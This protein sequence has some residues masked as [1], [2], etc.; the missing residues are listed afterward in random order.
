M[1]N[2][3][4]ILNIE[5]QLKQSKTYIFL[6]FAIVYC[7]ISFPNLDNFHASAYDLGIYNNSIYQYGH[8]INNPHP[9]GHL[10]LTNFLG[11][12]FALYTI[13]FSP[14]HYIFGIY[15]LL[16]IQIVF[17]LL[18]GYG[19]Y[20]L[21]KHMYPETILP[22]ISLFH[23]FTFYGIISALGFGYHDNVVASMLIPWFIYFLYI[24][25]IKLVIMF[26]ILICIGK[27][28][29]PLILSFIIIGYMLIFK[30]DTKKIKLLTLILIFSILYMIIV[31]KF[32]MPFFMRENVVYGHTANY[33]VLGNTLHEML[34]NIIFK[35]KYLITVLFTNHNNVIDY[36]SLKQE[37][38]MCLLLSGGIALL[39]KPEFLIMLIPIVFQKM[40]NNDQGK[41]GT[42]LHYSIEF[43]PIIILALYTTLNYLHNIKY[44]ISVAIVFC[45]LSYSVS[46]S[47]LFH[48]N[49][50]LQYNYLANFLNKGH[51]QSYFNKKSYNKL[52]SMI[53]EDAKLSTNNYFG[54]NLAFRKWIFLLP[55][56]VDANYIFLGISNYDF[57]QTESDLKNLV[58][59]LKNSKEWE[60]IAS[61]NE[62]YLFKKIN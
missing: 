31:I 32:I 19:I 18:G 49:G 45:F 56:I 60:L 22:E 51:Y 4:F 12:H 43:A 40:Y 47:R 59:N 3:Y 11:D 13:I 30:N 35:S 1:I 15:T 9:Y 29:M 21:V 52:V 20:T 37:T 28:N 54:P 17:I 57:L 36:D 14:L 10:A 61:E 23:F 55:D 53:P 27:E 39:I 2:T 50:D 41:W 48:R 8:L 33:S 6:L 58:Q 42:D 46:F 25:R 5:N 34:H 24:N 26:A 7:L 62:M 38:Y 44:K 16:V